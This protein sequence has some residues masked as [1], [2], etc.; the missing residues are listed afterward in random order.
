MTK[1][2]EA[3]TQKTSTHAIGDG[4]MQ[5]RLDNGLCPKCGTAWPENEDTCPV[6]S[7]TMLMPEIRCRKQDMT[8]KEAVLIMESVV[9]DYAEM[10]TVEGEDTS[11]PKKIIKAWERIQKG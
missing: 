3:T 2:S 4:S 9:K 5:K 8:W 11:W 7:L 1:Y 10:M 6:C